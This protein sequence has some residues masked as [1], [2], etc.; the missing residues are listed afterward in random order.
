VVGWCCVVVVVV[1]G[2]G[3]VGASWRSARSSDDPAHLESSIR[4]PVGPASS[5][6]MSILTLIASR[7]PT[8]C[9][10]SDAA[11]CTRSSKGHSR[12]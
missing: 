3:V 1:G 4:I 12:S 10:P 7:V 2:R 8:C 5:P 11:S 6:C 9:G